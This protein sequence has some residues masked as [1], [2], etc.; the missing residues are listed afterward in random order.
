MD[1]A[2]YAYEHQVPASELARVLETDTAKAEA[3][4]KDIETKRRTTELAT[5]SAKAPPEKRCA[6]QMKPM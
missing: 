2:L 4:Y 6:V 5:S 1:L 3:V